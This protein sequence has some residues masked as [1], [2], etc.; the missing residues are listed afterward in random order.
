MGNQVF[1]EAVPP[2]NH[3]VSGTPP[4]ECPMHNKG[5]TPKSDTKAPPSECPVQ[6]D[7]NI[8]PYNMVIILQFTT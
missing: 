6:H 2:K 3:D 4:P 5:T 7:S 1:A 8:N